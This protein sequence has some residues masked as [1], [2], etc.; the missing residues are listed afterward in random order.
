MHL[1]SHLLNGADSNRLI[2][3]ADEWYIHPDYNPNTLDNDVGLIKLR[4]PIEYTGK[5]YFK[6]ISISNVQFMED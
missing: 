2:V 1:G 4:M 5:L 3:A 6:L